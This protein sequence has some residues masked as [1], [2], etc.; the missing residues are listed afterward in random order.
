MVWLLGGYIWLYIHRPFEVWPVLGSLQLER[1]YMLAM[2][3][4]WAVAIDK[5]WIRNRL[6]V[7]FLVFASVLAA[8]WVFSRHSDLGTSRVEEW[9]KVAVFYA[10]V[11]S[12]I[13]SERDLKR[14]TFMYL[15]A[16]ALYM[17]HSLWEY[18][19]GRFQWTMGTARL[20]GIDVTNGDPN[21]FAATLVYSLPLALT[22]WRHARRWWQHGLLAGYTVLSAG[23]ILLT[24]SR[25][26]FVGLVFLLAVV[27]MTI[28]FR[29]SVRIFLPSAS[30]SASSAR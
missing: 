8:S 18:R 20:L 10:L 9:L 11:V 3:V 25:S 24:S 16:V 5:S 22:V 15:A 4:F 30:L 19:N 23:C 29:T 26:G 17:A 1:A 13:R 28:S 12:T 2:L 6:N 27:A 7:S 21:T 14:L